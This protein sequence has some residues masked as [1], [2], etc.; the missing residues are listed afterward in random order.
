MKKNKITPD[1]MWDIKADIQEALKHTEPSPQTRE[2]LA[3]LETNQLNLMQEINEIK[4]M[5][6]EL[7]NKLDCALDKK[8]DKWVQ[9]AFTW[10]MYAVG[11]GMIGTVGTLII[12]GIIY[13]NL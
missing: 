10:F 7:G 2:R 8:A 9:T 12:K 3:K 13:F 1:E 11:A 4:Q 5:I 6:S